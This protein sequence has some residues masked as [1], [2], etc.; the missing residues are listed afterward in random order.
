MNFFEELDRCLMTLEGYMGTDR[1]N[2]FLKN[3]YGD[4]PQENW[5]KTLR[6][7]RELLSDESRLY[8]IFWYIGVHDPDEMVDLTLKLFYLRFHAA[9][10]P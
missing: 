5:R 1:I 3:T 2:E 8:R 6:E 9:R 7:H 10:L 4:F